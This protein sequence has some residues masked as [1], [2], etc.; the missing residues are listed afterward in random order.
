ML[1]LNPDNREFQ[2]IDA[3]LAICSGDLDRAKKVACLTHLADERPCDID[4]ALRL[5]LRLRNIRD[6]KGQIERA[7]RDDEVL[8]QKL[9]GIGNLHAGKPHRAARIFRHAS[10]L[11]ESVS[12]DVSIARSVMSTASTTLPTC[13]PSA[14]WT[15]ERQTESS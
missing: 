14:Q 9:I 12:F 2:I 5:M 4:E 13:T 7:A 15:E 3:V 8:R 11:A 1:A 6:V 10:D